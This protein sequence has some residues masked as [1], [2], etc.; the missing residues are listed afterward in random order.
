MAESLYPIYVQ[1]N[2]I[3]RLYNQL[4]D[5]NEQSRK[6]TVSR[7]ASTKKSVS[8]NLV[9]S[10]LQAL[11]IETK[12]SRDKETGSNYGEEKLI[13]FEAEHR[14]KQIRLC[15]NQSHS[16]Y[17]LNYCI[18]SNCPFGSFIDFQGKAIFRRKERFVQ[19]HGTVESKNF[20]CICSPDYF[21]S[22]SYLFQT[23][24]HDYPT[25]IAGFGI[26]VA[27]NPTHL[28]IK[29]LLLAQYP[30]KYSF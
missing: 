18:A 13:V 2:A 20:L 22:K 11:G 28:E 4:T 30:V 27:A 5:S 8:F 17:D 19:V 9:A 7:N 26:I 23:M 24:R 29:P 15:L 3:N 6:N 16:L 1:D 25:Q 12:I 14:V 10:L 21:I